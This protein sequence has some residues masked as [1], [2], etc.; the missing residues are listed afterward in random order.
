MEK[1]GSFFFELTLPE[2]G[3]L[4]E[5]TIT[6]SRE[7]DFSSQAEEEG[8]LFMTQAQDT[9]YLDDPSRRRLTGTGFVFAD[10]R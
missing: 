10:L 7:R 9:V 2:L 3:D 1:N 6:G 5:V 4:G 8:E